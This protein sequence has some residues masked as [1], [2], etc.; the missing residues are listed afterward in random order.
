VNRSILAL[1][2]HVVAAAAALNTPSALAQPATAVAEAEPTRATEQPADLDALMAGMADTP[3]VV[4]EFTEIKKLAIL[5]APLETLGTLYFIPPD[6]MARH[7]SYPGTSSFV[8]DGDRLAFQDETGGDDLDLGSNPVAR[9]FVEN[10][11]VLFNG[12]LA[13]LRRRYDPTLVV[14]GDEWVLELKPRSPALAKMIESIEMRGSGRA[15]RSM[16]LRE[17]GGDVTETRFTK[18]D[19]NHRFSPDEVSRYFRA[20]TGAP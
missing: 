12:D 19:P 14:H 15:M 9:V 16:T 6:R 17:V 2:L 10:F 11:I 7:V 3:G 18:V 5:D 1:A 13:E 20:E 8:I 4:A